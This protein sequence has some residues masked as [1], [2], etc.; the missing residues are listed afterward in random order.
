MDFVVQDCVRFAFFTCTETFPSL[1]S[2]MHL[3]VIQLY[4]EIDLVII[5]V[6]GLS[7][8]QPLMDKSM[9]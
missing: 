2:A 3:P 9:Y 5:E 4:L 6:T 7:M 8:R 1:V